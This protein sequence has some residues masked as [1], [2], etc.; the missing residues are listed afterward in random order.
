[1]KEEKLILPEDDI[2]ARKFTSYYYDKNGE[3]VVDN[4]VIPKNERKF[5][6]LFGWI[7]VG[8][9]FACGFLLRGCLS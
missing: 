3:L 7:M 8:I 5:L 6:R 4:R 1:M 9:I 2:E